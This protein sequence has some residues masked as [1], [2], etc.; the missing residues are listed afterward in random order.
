MSEAKLTIA[1]PTFNRPAKLLLQ[2]QRVL[3]HLPPSWSVL[4]IDNASAEPAETVLQPILA[5]LG[6]QRLAVHR[7]PYN[8]GLSGNIIRCFELCPTEWLWILSDDDDV[9]PAAYQY[10]REMLSQRADLSFLNLGSNLHD[11]PSDLCFSS[12]GEFLRQIGSMVNVT[13][14]STGVYRVPV[15]NPYLRFGYLFGYSLCPFLAMLLMAMAEKRGQFLFSATKFLSA[16]KPSELSNTWSFLTTSL[17]I[18]SLL[19]LPLSLDDEEFK[20]LARLLQ[21]YAGSPRY[22][23]QVIENTYAPSQKAMRRHIIRQVMQRNFYTHR[24]NSFR[25]LKMHIL[26]FLLTGPA[27]IRRPLLAALGVSVHRAEEEKLLFARI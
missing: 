7:N 12:L 24:I 1:I 23:L 3:Q 8:I 21:A 17:A 16:E 26:S 20:N 25:A 5:E 6:E 9:E 10:I 19:E 13:L 2:V 14:I 22:L 18:T 11:I 4:V 15:F 27:A